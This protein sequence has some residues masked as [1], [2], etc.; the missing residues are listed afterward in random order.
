MSRS[1]FQ[2]PEMHI[3]WMHG[4][5]RW[6]TFWHSTSHESTMHMF[7]PEAGATCTAPEPRRDFTD[8]LCNLFPHLIPRTAKFPPPEPK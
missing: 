4:R 1:D 8:S 2:E 7:D 6:V 5:A 3:A